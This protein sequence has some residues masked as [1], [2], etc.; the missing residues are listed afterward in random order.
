[1]SFLPIL[2]TKRTIIR[3]T[4]M[5]DVNDYFEITSNPNVTKFCS[6]PTMK[7]IEQC[8][9]FLKSQIGY[10]NDLKVYCWSVILKDDP[11]KKVIGC[12]RL[13]Q[14]PKGFF[15]IRYYFDEKIWG[16]GIGKECIPPVID[17][18]FTKLNVEIIRGLYDIENIASGKVLADSGFSLYQTKYYQIFDVSDEHP[19]GYERVTEED[20]KNKKDGEKII[21]VIYTKIT[22]DEYFNK[23]KSK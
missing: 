10:E 1:M 11:N 5:D 15:N 20:Y 18:A 6:F 19:K 13:A 3:P 12:V 14:K 22:K 2:E 4:T 23:Q 21:P 16:K 7:S 8:E 9:T 17:A